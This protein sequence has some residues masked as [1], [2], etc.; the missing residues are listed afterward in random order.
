MLHQK[1]RTEVHGGYT[2]EIGFPAKT[3]E[4]SS[5]PFTQTVLSRVRRQGGAFVANA[6]IVMHEK[7]RDG[8]HVVD[9]IGETFDRENVPPFVDWFGGAEILREKSMRQ[10]IA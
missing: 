4:L 2:V 10:A 5:V 8:C 7:V 3:H 9:K 1:R 6:E